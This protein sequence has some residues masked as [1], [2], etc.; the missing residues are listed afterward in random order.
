MKHL[1]LYYPLHFYQHLYFQAVPVTP[2]PPPRRRR[3]H[4]LSV[5]TGLFL[6]KIFVDFII[7]AFCTL[8]VVMTLKTQ[9]MHMQ[10]KKKL[11]CIPRLN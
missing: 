11:S 2:L 1:K 9:T 6:T 3:Q 10:D 4:L 5:T 8:P 7:T